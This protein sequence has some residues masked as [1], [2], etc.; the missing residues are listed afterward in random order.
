MKQIREANAVGGGLSPLPG[1]GG[2]ACL[3]PQFRSGAQ[4]RAVRALC[5]RLSR[6]R[7]SRN[8]PLKIPNRSPIIAV[9]PPRH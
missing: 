4:P 8:P 5:G 2:V 3:E 7:V 9:H 1:L 6:D